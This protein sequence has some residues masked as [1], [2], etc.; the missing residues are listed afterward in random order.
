MVLQV[1][2]HRFRRL[3]LLVAA[4]LAVMI[5]IA[6]LPKGTL[7]EL[8][9]ALLLPPFFLGFFG[10]VAAFANAESDLA[11]E[12]SGYPPFLL[13]LPVRTSVLALF[14][15]LGVVI[16]SGLLWLG[17]AGLY[18]RPLGMQVAVWWP[19]TLVAALGVSF[20]AILWMPVRFGAFRLAFAI[21]LPSVSFVFGMWASADGWPPGQLAAIFSVE[22]L[23]AACIAVYGVQRARTT[24]AMRSTTREKVY[25]DRAKVRPAFKSPF[26]AQVWLEWRKQGRLLPF[27]TTMMLVLL[28]IPLFFQPYLYETDYNG[29]IKVNPWLS[30][31]IM[32][33]PWI[34]LL[35]A[36]VLG[37]GASKSY[38]R[39]AEGRY[40]LYFA[41]RP[42]S[43]ADMIRAKYV[44]ITLGVLTSWGILLLIVLG[45]LMFPAEDRT[46]SAN[47]LAFALERQPPSFWSTTAGVIALLILCTWRNQIV[48]AFVDFTSF[49]SIR[50]I[51]ATAVTVVGGIFYALLMTSNG[52]YESARNAPVLAAIFGCL[53]ALKFGLSIWMGRRLVSVQP[54]ESGRVRA[55]LMMWPVWALVFGSIAWWFAHHVGKD[56][57]AKAVMTGWTPVLGTLLLIPLVRPMAARLAVELGRHR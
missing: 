50:G 12:T 7:P 29:Y 20:Q 52:F 56:F 16:W 46:H 35:V 34:P 37:M 5:A 9:T 15:M 10:T 44:S 21:L 23:V 51:Y 1:F 45:W 22:G 17:V 3:Y 30:S 4:Y 47:T 54:N 42:L 39:S 26:A 6:L 2:V 28:S 11:S 8:V 24:G 25:R 31:W 13:R 55:A 38:L 14:P 33:L 18:M 43:S 36:T 40:H 27:I 32:A 19:V 53:L 48:G 41:T 57:Y 49:P